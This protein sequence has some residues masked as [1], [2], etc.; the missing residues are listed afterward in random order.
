MIVPQ[1]WAE[2]RLQQ[3]HQGKQITVRRFG[4]SDIDQADAQTT[5]DARAQEALARLLAGEKLERRELKVPYHGAF[6]VPIREEIVSRHGSTVI[7]RNS[8][9][10]RCLNTPD[11]LFADIDFPEKSVWR[12]GC[13]VYMALLLAAVVIGWITH[14]KLTGAVTAIV[15]LFAAGPAIRWLHRLRP[16]DSPSAETLAR[17]RIAQ[18]AQKHADWS[19]RIYR[20]PAGLRVMVTH[21]PFEPAD[22]MVDTFFKALGTDTVY[23]IMCRNQQ[24]FRARVSPK[25]WRIGIQ[26]HMRPRPGVWPVNPELLPLRNEWIAHYETQAQSWAACRLIET[27][28]SGVIHPEVQAVLELHD[29]MCKA[30]VAYLPIA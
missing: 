13:L 14:S 30:T 3:R 22:P 23:A 10:A 21:Q 28:G 2:A 1:Y 5:A 19:L 27:L 26:K 25:P 18:F 6:G 11:T 17:S 24:C 29:V 7:T 15:A 8:Y 12:A 4:W 20:T 16:D 9:G